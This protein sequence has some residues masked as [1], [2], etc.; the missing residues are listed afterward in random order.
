[1]RIVII[2]SFVLFSELVSAQEYKLDKV[3][4]LA[5]ANNHNIKVFQNNVIIADNIA[6]PG[7]AGLLPQFSLNGGV[8]YSSNDTK[9]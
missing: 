4:E 8:N 9:L 7:N 2:L 5:L 3:L 6:D 1:M